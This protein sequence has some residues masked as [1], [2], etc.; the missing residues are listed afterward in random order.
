[1]ADWFVYALVSALF[2]GLHTFLLKVSVE[3]KYDTYLL[4]GASS[5]VAF[6][7]GA[8]IVAF[9]TGW[10]AVPV[11]VY[12]FAIL[13]GVLFTIMTLARMEGLKF[14]D[15]AIFFPLYKVVGPALVAIMAIVFLQE[16]VGP[17]E[18]LGIVLSCAVPL[19]L[20][21]RAEHAR[22]NNL[23]LG[24]IFLVIGATVSAIAAIVNA[25]VVSAAVSSALPLATVENGLAGL[26]TALLFARKHP[27]K[28]FYHQA[29]PHFTKEFM[30]MCLLNGA[31][32]MI[33]SYTLFLAFAGGDASIAYSVTAHYILI[34]VLLSVWFYKEHWNL[35]KAAAL[36]LSILALILLHQ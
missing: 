28:E 8:L 18:L 29:H 14:L 4:S 19:L 2:A 21:T 16:H 22:Q 33:S 26:F 35:Q 5:F 31:F 11:H 3:R 30:G 12:L 17:V 25:H 15:S 9:T 24:L 20:I 10:G 13:G 23:K 1:M 32:Q 7:G 36:F 6:A 34:P 27:A